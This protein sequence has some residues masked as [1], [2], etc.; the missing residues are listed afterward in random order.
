MFFRSLLIYG[1]LL[2]HL[3]FPYSLSGNKFGSF[4]L[5]SFLQSDLLTA[6]SWYSSVC[7]SV[8]SISCKLGAE[9]RGLS[10]HRSDAFNKVKVVLCFVSGLRCS[11]MLVLAD[12]Q[13]L[14]P[15]IHWELK[16]SNILIL[17][18]LLIIT[19]HT[20]IKRHFPSSTIL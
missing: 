5:S 17:Y 1:F 9:S 14:H 7:S 3:S 16:N 18:V 12:L 10:W 11:L 15:L 20:F 4:S 2:P 8:F 19:W 13:C 6:H